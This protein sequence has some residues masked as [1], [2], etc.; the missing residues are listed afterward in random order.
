MPLVIVYLFKGWR[1]SPKPVASYG[2]ITPGKGG[3]SAPID[4]NKLRSIAMVIS[5][6]LRNFRN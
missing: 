6:N 4:Q 1:D 5:H 3:K 2:W